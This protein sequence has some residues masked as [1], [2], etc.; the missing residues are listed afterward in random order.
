MTKHMN[1]QP[2]PS[3]ANLEDWFN[4]AQDRA[5][6][7]FTTHTRI[8]TVLSAIV[9]AFVL[10]LDSLEL[11]Q[12]ISSDADL[13]SKLVAQADSVEKE[14][15]KV[16]QN[17]DVGSNAANKQIVA[18]LQKSYPE[19]AAKLD[20][21]PKYTTLSD[22]DEWI[23]RQL[24]GTAKLEEIVSRYNQLFFQKNLDLASN[25]L[26]QLSKRLD[27][28]GL[29]LLRSPYPEVLNDDHAR[30]WWQIFSGK[31]SW[32]PRRLFGI[33]VSAGLLSLGSPFWF[34]TLKSLTNLRPKL[35]EQID[36]HS[37]QSPE[38]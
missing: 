16:L 3:L 24:S 13:R 6:Q 11:I 2:D 28:S 5:R 23:R 21:P 1:S 34:N 29:E 15:G 36:K 18:E 33:L 32:P 30:K 27:Q 25:N 35:A 8:I 4:S 37:K 20:Q 10:Q 19:I 9:A 31:W 7:W 38:E 17:V 22:V 26:E 12:R 14:V